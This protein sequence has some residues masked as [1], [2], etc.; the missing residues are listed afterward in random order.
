MHADTDASALSRVSSSIPSSAELGLSRSSSLGNSSP[1]P[2]SETPLGRSTRHAEPL[3][4]ISLPRDTGT[5]RER[6]RLDRRPDA[7]VVRWN[8]ERCLVEGR[9]AL[10][11]KVTTLELFDIVTANGKP[12]RHGL[13]AVTCV[14][15]NQRVLGSD[16]TCE[17]QDTQPQIS[18]PIV[19]EEIR[20]LTDLRE[21]GAN[22]KKLSDQLEHFLA[23]A[24]IEE[25]P[26]KWPE[27]RHSPGAEIRK[28]VVLAELLALPQHGYALAHQHGDQIR[29]DHIPSIA[30]PLLEEGVACLI[31]IRQAE[32]AQEPLMIM[33]LEILKGRL[34]NEVA[35]GVHFLRIAKQTEREPPVS[36]SPA[37]TASDTPRRIEG[38]ILPRAVRIG[39]A[40]NLLRSLE[41]LGTLDEPDREASPSVEPTPVELMLR[42][43]RL[44][45]LVSVV[46]EAGIPDAEGTVPVV[47]DAIVAEAVD[48]I[49]L[50]P[51]MV[52]GQE[53]VTRKLASEIGALSK[54]AEI[55]LGEWAHEWVFAILETRI[56][57]EVGEI[58]PRVA[59]DGIDDDGD[60]MLVGDVDQL[61]KICSL[62]ES[63]V[64]PE[65][66]DG[67]VSPIDRA[68][69]VRERHHLDGIHPEVPQIG[70]QVAR[71]LEI[72]AELRDVDLIH[73][74]I[75]EWRCLPIRL[76]PAPRIG[77]ISERES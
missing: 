1:H 6:R 41:L 73:H 7:T 75:R 43:L 27:Q 12:E 20:P 68:G 40:K 46:H 15:G 14:R 11:A 5:Q 42:D 19:E 77:L 60:A 3:V 16:I 45:Q 49:H 62:P 44:G 35:V 21:P 37:I 50:Q 71:A 61:L 66:P 53:V 10:Q 59:I 34:G 38:A 17:H 51:V 64:D 52:H 48:V 22:A 56:G 54:I 74:Q 33:V 63:L 26:S 36:Q 25:V 18:V 13:I 8:R 9:D 2:K 57:V 32:V 31:W 23:R 70:D 55:I 39:G 24:I 30:V 67:K 65:E 72:A 29:L 58:D 28:V 47:R 4:T 76:G 69:H